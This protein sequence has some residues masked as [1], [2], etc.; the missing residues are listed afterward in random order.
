LTFIVVSRFIITILLAWEFAA[1]IWPLSERWPVLEPI[2]QSLPKM[3][4]VIGVLALLILS[5]I[6]VRAYH[7]ERLDSNSLVTFVN[8][9]KIQ[10]RSI[11]NIQPGPSGKPRLLLSDQTTYRQLYPYLSREFD[12]QLTD[13]A[14]KQYPGAPRIIELLQG[15][16]TIWVLPTGPQQQT[17]NNAVSGRGQA[18][19]AFNFE[20]LGTA[21][22]YGFRANIEPFIA[23]ARFGNGIEL[24]AHQVELQPGA[25]EVTLYWRA[26]SS[27]SQ[28]YKVFT[29]LLDNDG[30]LVASHDGIPANGLAPINT[31]PVG[32]VQ[33]DRHRIELPANLAPGNYRLIT[34][35][36]N[37]FGERLSAIAPDGFN[38][39]DRAV[40]LPPV[41]IR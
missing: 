30:Q 17:L 22:L 15:L 20:D 27:Q 16:D 9:I 36:Y 11:E 38:F 18:L 19:A 10:T 24:L 13:G 5:P 25:V 31:W 21:S 8:F 35:L 4:G 34:G 1:I 37:D 23:P 12:L 40:R 28:S 2:R 26:L 32:P 7:T 6:L 3:L 39:A 41:Q 29:Q 33:A 14:A